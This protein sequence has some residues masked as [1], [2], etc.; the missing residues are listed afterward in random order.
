MALG[1]DSA[2][3]ENEYQE[4]FLGVKLAGA[5]CWP[6]RQLHVSN[7]MKI[8]EFKPH[9]TLW[10]TPGMLRYLKTTNCEISSLLTTKLAELVKFMCGG[11]SS[12]YSS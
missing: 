8:W 11:F 3:S 1:V 5:W 7:V 6:P 12:L 2:P 10:D 4:Y 9:G